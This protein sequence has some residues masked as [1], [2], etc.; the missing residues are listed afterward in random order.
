MKKILFTTA[1]LA[2]IPF[3]GSA[4][5]HPEGTK[6]IALST[7]VEL[8]YMEKG[9]AGGVPVIFL[10]GICDSWHSFQQVLE[11]L[12]PG[13]H[14]FALSQRGH[15][16]SE[17]PTS[18]YTPADFAADVAA[19]IK[20]KNL[21]S[22]IVVGH[23]M[24]GVN[25]QQFVLNH[26]ELARGIVI[27][28]SDPKLSENPGMPEFYNEVMKMSGTIPRPFMEDFQRATLTRPIDSAYFELLVTEGM[29]PPVAVFQAAFKGLMEV[30]FTTRLSEIRK[31]VF[32][33]WGDK[34]SFCH[35]PGQEPFRK[36][37]KQGK[38]IVYPGFGHAIHW[39]DPQRVV[40]DLVK[41]IE[42][43]GK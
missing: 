12:P 4:S 7:G 26:P 40:N 35:Q 11:L 41:F 1:A 15:G 34:D 21:G 28:A 43:I 20:Q 23:S 42:G 39:E 37:L 5:D 17:R 27:I 24:G 10:H 32:V 19:F 6:R 8:E 16:D 29:K 2:I 3:I 36:N 33:L 18:G 30:D 38:Y 31:P 22:A 9:E 14:G 25:A 13:I